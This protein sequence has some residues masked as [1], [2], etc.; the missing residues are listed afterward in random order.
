VSIESTKNESLLA[1][2]VDAYEPTEADA[3]RVF[4]KIQTSL[5][6]AA[7]A[8]PTSPAEAPPPAGASVAAGAHGGRNALLIGLSCAALVLT[9]AVAF[10]TREAPMQ[11]AP[12]MS[13]PAAVAAPAPAEP[14]EPESA[15]VIPSVTVDSLPG[16]KPLQP[17]ANAEKKAVRPSPSA[18]DATPQSDTLEREAR[19]LSHARQARQAG[20][21][22]GALA[23]L[24]EHAR[25]FPNGWLANERAVERI[26]VLCS[27]GRR[28]E[29]VREAAAFLKGRA[30]SPLTR[31][32]ELSCAGQP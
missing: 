5:S 23:L 1:P 31:R 9:G 8:A 2:L 16:A 26:V 28:D 29:A 11:P 13:S 32:V 3:D 21:S 6:E 17:A 30:M 15:A 20:E 19:L 14:H 18:T 24:D 10:T 25:T 27:L 4:E 22:A 12:A 7:I